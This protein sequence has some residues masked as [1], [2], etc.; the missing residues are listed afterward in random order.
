VRLL[1]TVRV[2]DHVDASKMTLAEY[3]DRWEAGWATTQVGPK[4]RERYVELLRLHVRP[5]IGALPLHK[6]QL[7][8]LTDLYG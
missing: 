6:L 2:G 1:E 5:H 7:V 3:L 4:T 8:H